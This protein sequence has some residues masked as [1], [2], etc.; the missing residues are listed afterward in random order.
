MAK[1]ITDNLAT[2][3]F[4]FRCRDEFLDEI[5]NKTKSSRNKFE[6]FL[7]D[8]AKSEASEVVCILNKIIY[9]TFLSLCIDL[10]FSVI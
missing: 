5:L 6:G 8:W 3:Y 9:T 4:V 10:L 1:S 2:I 7:A